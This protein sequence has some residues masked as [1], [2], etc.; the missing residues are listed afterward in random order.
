[1]DVLGLKDVKVERVCLRWASTYKDR[2][3]SDQG[4]SVKYKKMWEIGVHDA[5]EEGKY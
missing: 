5:C 3:G 1:M 4:L 2:T